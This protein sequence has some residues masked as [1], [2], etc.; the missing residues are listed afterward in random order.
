MSAAI[1]AVAYLVLSKRSLTNLH[2]QSGSLYQASILDRLPIV[3]QQTIVHLIPSPFGCGRQATLGQAVPQTGV[4][5]Q[6]PK[7]CPI[8]AELL[9][10]TSQAF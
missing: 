1:A 2:L 7:P 9:G 3:L 10:A 8:A 6:A 5:Q 4:M